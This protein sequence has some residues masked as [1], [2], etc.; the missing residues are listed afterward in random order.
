MFRSVVEQTG[1]W[2]VSEPVVVLLI[3]RT[4]ELSV[5][6]NVEL[7]VVPIPNVELSVL[8][9]VELSDTGCSGIY[10][11]LAPSFYTLFWHVQN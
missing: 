5:V 1:S 10:T 2:A 7:S 3:V 11:I 6:P 8:P 9:K 4:V